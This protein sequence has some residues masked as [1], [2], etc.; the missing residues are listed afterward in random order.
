MKNINSYIHE[1]NNEELINNAK[2]IASA[3][4]CLNDDNGNYTMELKS[5]KIKPTLSEKEVFMMAKEIKAIIQ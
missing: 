2:A 4:I 5:R 1:S 3:I